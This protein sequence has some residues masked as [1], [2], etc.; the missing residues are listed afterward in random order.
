MTTTSRP[1]ATT[2]SLFQRSTDVPCMTCGVIAKHR[3]EAGSGPHH[4]SLICTSC[5]SFIKWLA[6]PQMALAHKQASWR[7]D[8]ATDKQLATLGNMRLPH[9]P[10]ISKGE[11]SQLIA[12]AL[13][14]RNR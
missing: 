10:D 6:K 4:A 11:A 13:A 14:E 3:I 9:A 7:S 1:S 12:A 2:T 8:P 5:S